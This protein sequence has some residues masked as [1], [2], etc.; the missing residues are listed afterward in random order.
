M[1]GKFLVKPC[2]NNPVTICCA[3]VSRILICGEFHRQSSTVITTIFPWNGDLVQGTRPI[4]RLEDDP[5]F[6]ATEA[7]LV[8][9][10]SVKSDQVHLL[11]RVHVL[12]LINSSSGRSSR[13][14]LLMLSKYLELRRP[15]LS[16]F[17]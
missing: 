16:S 2:N 10:T 5:R 17:S 4:L 1:F 12:R 15:T 9:R 6:R 14:I 3:V 13:L 7:Q 8:T 11:Q